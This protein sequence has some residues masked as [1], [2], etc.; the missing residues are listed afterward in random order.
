MVCSTVFAMCILA[1]Y[2]DVL[3]CD[4]VKYTV[5]YTNTRIVLIN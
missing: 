5:K 2:T 1:M 3:N 4:T